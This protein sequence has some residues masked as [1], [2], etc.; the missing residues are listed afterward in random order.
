MERIAMS[1]EERDCLNWLKRAQAGSMSQRE[2]GEKMC[3]S[4][5]WVRK[6]LK[7]MA[8]QGDAV[9]VHGLRGRPSN[10]KLSAQTQRQAL[11]IL[12]QPDWH[13]F[14]PTFASEQLAKRHQI[15][16]GK[17]T[18]RGWM[19]EA[20]LWKSKSRRLQEVHSWR[21]RRSAFG[22]LVQWDTSEHDWLEGRGPV[23]YLVRMI[24]DATSWSW[25]RFVE[26]DATPQNMGVLW[27]YL[28]KNGRM[29]DVYTDRDSMFAVP[30]RP[31]ESK[32]QQREADRL[33]QL[34]RALRELGIGSIL[35]YSPQAKGRIERSF[36]TAQDRLVK[37]LRLAKVSTLEAANAFLEKEY[38]PDWN[39]HFARPVADFANQHRAMTP[40]LDLG[41]ILCHVEERV[42]GN[43]YTFSFAGRRHQIARQDAQAGMRH[44]QLRVELRLNGELKA[45]YQGQ[46]VNIA[47]C[48]ARALSL[49]P[50]VPKPVRKD[51]NAGGKSSWMQGFFDRPSPPLWKTIG[52]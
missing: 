13:D 48:G 24:D 50:A 20:G 5:R 47:E 30:P 16:V 17:E 26:C 28:E 18:L 15:Q 41:A 43:D 35:A 14:G 31:G 29:V 4:A 32:D 46:Y 22:E 33:T 1:Q 2:A 39:A 37:H 11:A 9:V 8:K 10:R 51:H 52:E 34:G 19:M 3:V 6:L 38:W 49:P 42:I 7:R 12:K 40:Q 36:L 21:P 45:R 23:R 44:Q 25:G 27:E